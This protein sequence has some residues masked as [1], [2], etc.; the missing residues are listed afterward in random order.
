MNHETAS[1]RGGSDLASGNLVAAVLTGAWR[2]L[3]ERCWLP[4]RS[5]AQITPLLLET[6]AG[7]LGWWRVRYSGAASTAAALRLQ[8]AYRFHR[9]WAARQRHE[10]HEAFTALRSAGVEPLLAKGWAVA[11][12]YADPGL[13]PYGDVDLCVRPEHY[14]VARA[15]LL[16]PSGRLVDLHAG[17]PYLDDRSLEEIYARSE[18]VALGDLEVRILGPEDH[19]RLLC[20]HLLKHGAR[21]PLWLCDIGAALESLP[22]SFDWAYFLGGDQRRSHWVTCVLILAHRLLGARLDEVPTG[23]CGRQLPTWL[24]PAVLRQWGVPEPPMRPMASYL[25]Q[26]AGILH[27]IRDRWPGPIEG[28]VRVGGPFDELPRL[29]FQLSAFL[30]RAGSFALLP[31]PPRGSVARPR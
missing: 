19:L 12:L 10:L 17:F 4:A 25:R 31:V 13:R 14:M 16:A 3:P 26:P 6:G 21:R 9:L 30:L 18:M 2:A 5:L 23:V 20:L 27:A 8:Q 15:A 28:T 22:A 11:R 29:P 24:G 7:G 1:S